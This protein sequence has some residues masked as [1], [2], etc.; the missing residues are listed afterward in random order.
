MRSRRRLR[1]ASN[2]IQQWYA[3]GLH[4]KS[5]SAPKARNMIARG[6]RRAQ[7]G[8]SPLVSRNNL[9]RALKVRNITADIPLFQS[10]R[11]HYTLSRGDALRCAPR[12]PLAFIFRAVGVARPFRTFEARPA[13]LKV[14]SCTW[15]MSVPP[16]VAGGSMMSM[17]YCYGF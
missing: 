13:A 14:R 2:R 16:A 10:F 15:T 12:L 5:D 6:K 4:K 1:L 7:R 11:A 9:K 8:A 3:R 17:R